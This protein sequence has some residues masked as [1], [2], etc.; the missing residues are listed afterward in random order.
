[1]SNNCTFLNPITNSLATL[2]SEE[3]IQS[4]LMTLSRDFFWAFQHVCNKRFLPCSMHS[5]AV[6]TPCYS[7]SCC[8]SVYPYSMW[9][10]SEHVGYVEVYWEVVYMPYPRVI[11]KF[12]SKKIALYRKCTVLGYWAHLLG[13]SVKKVHEWV[14]PMPCS[15]YS[16]PIPLSI[17]TRSTCY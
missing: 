11:L 3:C 17:T 2:F 5:A 12:A 4:S 14:L 15:A 1:M 8:T 9:M 7:S 13:Q 6:L 10:Y 16:Y